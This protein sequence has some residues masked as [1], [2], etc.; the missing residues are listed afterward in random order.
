MN[1]LPVKFIASP[2]IKVLNIRLQEFLRVS[3]KLLKHTQNRPNSTKV[4]SFW[5]S[6]ALHQGQVWVLLDREWVIGRQGKIELEKHDRE[7]RAGVKQVETPM[8]TPPLHYATPGD[9]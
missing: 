6:G 8:I 3:A 5:I 1:L 7:R 2:I 9:I 4:N